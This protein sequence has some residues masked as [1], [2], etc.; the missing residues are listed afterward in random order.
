MGDNTGDYERAVHQDSSSSHNNICLYCTFS[1]NRNNNRNNFHVIAVFL[2]ECNYCCETWSRI[3]F[4]AFITRS[5][6]FVVFL[7]VH[8]CFGWFLVW[9]HLGLLCFIVGEFDFGSVQTFEFNHTHILYWW[10]ITSIL[11]WWF[12]FNINVFWIRFFSLLP[13]SCW[14]PVV[15]ESPWCLQLLVA[16]C[17]TVCVTRVWGD[18]FFLTFRNLVDDPPWFYPHVISQ[19][20]PF[21]SRPSFLLKYAHCILRIVR[22]SF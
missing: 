17:V 4:I 10:C 11:Y 13:F 9:S 8:F 22:N 3:C 5:H 1:D 2:C 15:M 7:S 18:F 14:R 12:A 16:G 19:C 21:V 6:I 20:N